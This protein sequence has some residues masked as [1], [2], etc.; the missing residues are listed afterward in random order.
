MN[1]IRTPIAG[2]NLKQAASISSLEKNP[3]RGQIPAIE[4]QATRKV[5]WVSGMY[6]RSPPMADISLEWTAWIMQPA[7]R[8]RSALN[9]AC[10]K[11]WNIEA[12]YPS[13]P[14]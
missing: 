6:L 13:P 3:L 14:S 4:R 12:M 10:V 9:I 5:M 11:R 7:P 8:K 1:V 2:L